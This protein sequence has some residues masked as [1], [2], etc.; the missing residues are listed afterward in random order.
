MLQRE[1]DHLESTDHSWF[2][3][4]G[5][6]VDT[7]GRC[8]ARSHQVRSSRIKRST[9]LQIGVQTAERTLEERVTVTRQKGRR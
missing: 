1:S 5:R 3:Q 4:A 6:A 7:D 9:S 2:V 8:K